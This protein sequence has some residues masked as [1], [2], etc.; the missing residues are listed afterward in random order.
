MHR[1][2]SVHMV[3]RVSQN[4]KGVSVVTLEPNSMRNACCVYYNHLTKQSM[5]SQGVLLTCRSML[6]QIQSWTD[7][8][9][10]NSLICNNHFLIHVMEVDSNIWINFLD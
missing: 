10:A 3:K 4:H 7:V 1:P 9:C 6:V 8:V 2:D 5:C